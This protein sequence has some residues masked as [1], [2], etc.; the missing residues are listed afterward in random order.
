MNA[1]PPKRAVIVFAMNDTTRQLGRRLGVAVQVALKNGALPRPGCTAHDVM[2]SWQ[3]NGVHTQQRAKCTP[4]LPARSRRAAETVYH[5]ASQASSPRKHLA[6]AG[7]WVWLVTGGRLSH[8]VPACSRRAP[9]H[10]ARFAERLK[11]GVQRQPFN[12]PEP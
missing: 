9:C 4:G 8:S 1:Q 6:K 3:S 12:P 10:D 2:A 5:A 7:R 11:P